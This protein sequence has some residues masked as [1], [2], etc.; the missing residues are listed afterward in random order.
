MP[1]FGVLQAGKSSYGGQPVW[2][3]DPDNPQ[4][5]TISNLAV[6]GTIWIGTVQSVGPNNTNEST[7][8]TPGGYLSYDGTQPVYYVIADAPNV[9][10]VIYPGVVS[11]FQPGGVTVAGAAP[12]PPSEDSSTPATVH[13]AVTGQPYTGTTTAFS[14]PANSWLIAIVNIINITPGGGINVAVSDSGGHTW[15][16]VDHFTDT[17]I[18][19]T[20]IWRAPITAAPGSITVSAAVSGTGSSD[21]QFSVRVVNNANA[22]QST[23]GHAST[24]GSS[25]SAK[26][27]IVTTK[28]GSL[29]YVAATLEGA[30]GAQTPLSGTSAIDEFNDGV[31]GNGVFEAGKSSANTSVPGS[32][33]FGWSSG[34]SLN[35]VWCAVEVIP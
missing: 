31:S 32:T 30:G 24:S 6:N 18:G 19:F 5:F 27:N 4:P 15:T 12:I 16:Q 17:A 14:P 33:M 29:V 20:S 1:I 35:W 23:A 11:V 25:A 34:A 21:M 8:V 7:P 2:Y 22:N 13:I 3:G 9:T 28:N 26:G 10:A